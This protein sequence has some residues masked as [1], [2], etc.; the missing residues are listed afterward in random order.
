MIEGLNQGTDTVRTGLAYVLGANLENLVLTGAAAVNAN[1][2][3]LDNAMTGNSAANS[4]AGG[5]GDDTL[6]GNGGTDTLVGGAGNDVLIVDDL[7]DVINEIAAGGLD[8][9]KSAVS[10]TLSNIHLENLELTGSA[11]NGTGNAANNVIVGNAGNNVLLGDDGNDLIAGGGGTDSIS[12]EDGNDTLSGVGSLAT[13]TGGAGNDAYFVD[14]NDTI[15][16]DGGIDT[17]N[18]HV[19]YTLAADL[20]NLVLVDN[21]SA[22]V[23]NGNAL[24]NDITGNDYGNNLSGGDGNDTVDGG[25][26]WDLLSG[27]IGA[28]SLIGGDGNDTLDGGDGVDRMFGG[29]GNDTFVLSV[30]TDV[31]LENAGQGFDIVQSAFAYNLA[32]NVEGLQLLGS[33]NL[34]GN[35][36]AG[37]NWLMGNS[38][39]NVLNGGA[40]ND[41]LEGGAG[42]D[43]LVGSTGNDTYVVS[44]LVDTIVEVK[45]AGLDTVQT[46]ID[47]SL[48]SNNA[49]ENLVLLGSGDIDGT[50][51]LA[52]NVIWG[53]SGKNDISGSAGNDTIYGGAG[54]DDLSGSLGNDHVYGGEGA[55]AI[56]LNS[57]SDRVYYMDVLDAGDLLQVFGTSGGFQDYVMLDGLFDS[58]G[59]AAAS[60]ASRVSLVSNGGSTD[61]W[62]DTD[63]SNGAD[64]HLLTFQA[65]PDTSVLSVG[66]SATSDIVVGT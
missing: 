32:V 33:A 16:D 1:G 15:F 30:A 19:N 25:L 48:G 40:G 49:L 8:T 61:L 37:N 17:V 63:G 58:L 21:P 66:N 47:Y 13:L 39:N 10:I 2:N 64:L 27:E 29:L 28:D 4:L 23:G 7:G 6:N 24:N 20:E 36:N 35:G 12:G 34:N 44:D 54:N 38:G 59:V 5:N 55:D 18:S 56:N 31:V 43:T 41:T 11:T 45:G 65:M 62:I 46:W 53:N 50:G 60:R 42:I 14:G 22:I 9:V 3:A 51:N 52:H 26:G 57:G